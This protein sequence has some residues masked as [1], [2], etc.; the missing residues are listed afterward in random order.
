MWKV[1][2]VW[3]TGKGRM[4]NMVIMMIVWW[5]I[6]DMANNREEIGYIECMVIVVGSNND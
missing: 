6:F 2:P 4:V 5:S 3:F 1:L